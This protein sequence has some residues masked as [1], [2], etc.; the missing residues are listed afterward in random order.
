[1]SSRNTIAFYLNNQYQEVGPDFAR[2]MLSDYLRYQSCLTGTK[3]VCAEGDCGACTVLISRFPLKGKPDF[4][5]LNSCIIPVAL[6]HGRHIITVEAISYQ[7]RFHEVQRAMVEGNGSQCGFCTPGF[8][9]ALAGLCEKKLEQNNQQMN[10]KEIKNHLTGNLCRCTGYQDIIDSVQTVN[11]KK[12]QTLKDRYHNKD[13]AQKLQSVA[14]E[15]VFLEGEDFSFFAPKTYSEAINY[16]NEK[17]DVQIIAGATDL[18]VACNKRK[19]KF[20]HLMSLCLI[21]EAFEMN[22]C[23]KKVVIGPWVTIAELRRFLKGKIDEYVRYLDIFASP[24]IKNI[25]TVVGNIVNASPIGDSAPPLLALGGQISLSS[26]KGERTLELDQFFTGYRKTALAPEELV[27]KICFP[28]PNKSAFFKCYK[29]SVR[30]DL[31]ISTVNVAI[32][33]EVE[34]NVIKKIKIAA[35]GIAATP[36]RLKATEEFLL[37]Q[38]ITEQVVTQACQIAQKEFNPLNDLRGSAAYRRI[39]VSNYIRRFF[40]ELGV[41]NEKRSS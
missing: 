29:N 23:D 41:Y 32:T 12:E 16:L 7:D 6:L 25:A 33:L 24:Q 9:V 22:I 20:S 30:K 1:M 28:L 18:G 10:E 35:G 27:T 31:D 39:L 38:S 11:L 15:S 19:T 37:E 26:S 13:I 3:V 4:M 2:L 34:H 8:I 17:K 40:N 5:T 14:G 36:L 21:E